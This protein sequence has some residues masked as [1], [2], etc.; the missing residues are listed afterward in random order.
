[1]GDVDNYTSSCGKSE[2]STDATNSIAGLGPW[3]DDAFYVGKLGCVNSWA[4]TQE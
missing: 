4:E 3:Q 2:R 1:M